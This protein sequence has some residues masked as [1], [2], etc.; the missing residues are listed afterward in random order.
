MIFIKSNQKIFENMYF[1]KDL[2]WLD[3]NGLQSLLGVCCPSKVEEKLIS[4][5]DFKKIEESGITIYLKDFK[6]SDLVKPDAVLQGVYVE[7]CDGGDWLF[8]TIK[9]VRR[10]FFL[11]NGELIAEAFDPLFDDVLKVA[12]KFMANQDIILEEILKLLVKLL[13]KNYLITYEIAMILGLF[14]T[15]NVQNILQKIFAIPELKQQSEELFRKIDDRP[16]I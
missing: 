14:D 6:S 2:Y 15:E 4:S 10:R 16:E 13:Q 7:L 11:K 12:E 1:D 5:N 8:P 9:D 3:P